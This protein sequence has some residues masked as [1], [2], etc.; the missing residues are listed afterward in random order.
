MVQDQLALSLEKRKLWRRA[1]TRWSD[2]LL[3]G[4][5]SNS[6]MDW[7]LARKE[8]CLRQVKRTVPY[9]DSSSLQG[10]VNASLYTYL[11]SL[12]K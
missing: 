11:G 9:S 12:S 4:D 5:L 6:E 1:A 8:Y 7:V 10:N 3:S 2:L